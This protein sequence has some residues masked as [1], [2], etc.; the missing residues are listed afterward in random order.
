MTLATSPRIT[1]TTFA[2]RATLAAS[3]AEHVAAMLERD[4]DRSGRTS[5]ALSGGT[6]PRLFLAALARQSLPWDKVDITLVDER[7]VPESSESSNMGMVRSLLAHG[8]AG[9]ARF[10]PLFTGDL[11][12]EGVLGRVEALLDTISLPLSVAVLGMGEDGHTASFFPGGDRLSEALDPG[13]QRRV[14]PMNAPGVVQPRIT[15]TLP[16]LIS[17]RNLILHIEGEAKRCVLE[18]ALEPGPAEDL[19]IRAILRQAQQLGIVWA[20]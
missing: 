16:V 6:T 19:P 11:N 8:C 10:V 14:L 17:A 1:L 12:P 4:I 13:G 3:L 9:A 20:P 7:W 2:D 5:L 18:H 15:L